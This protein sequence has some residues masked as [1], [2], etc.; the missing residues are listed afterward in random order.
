MSKSFSFRAK[1]QKM[2]NIQPH[3]KCK[4]YYQKCFRRTKVDREAECILASKSP[5]E[6]EYKTF[7]EISILSW[8]KTQ[9]VYHRKLRQKRHEYESNV[10]KEMIKDKSKSSRT[11]S[12]ATS[13]A[14]RAALGVKEDQ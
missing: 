13:K 14:R 11:V 9:L 5:D 1:S 6:L 3:T 2:W 10:S 7:V 4:L 8:K 12:S